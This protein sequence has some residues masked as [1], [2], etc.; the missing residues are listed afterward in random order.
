[1][2][3]RRA[4][5][6]PGGISAESNQAPSTV[7]AFFKAALRAAGWVGQPVEAERLYDLMLDPLEQHNLIGQPAH[8]RVRTDLRARLDAWMARTHDPI[9]AG[10]IPA[11]AGI[12]VATVDDTSP[13]DVP[14][15]DEAASLG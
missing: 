8:E 9:L 13:A 3:Q 1:M 4:V 2:A 5:D 12:R 10:P 7:K 14:A 6:R 11:P 15:A